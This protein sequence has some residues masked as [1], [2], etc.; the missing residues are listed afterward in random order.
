MGVAGLLSPSLPIVK[1]EVVALIAE[2]LDNHEIAA[3]AF[4]SEGTVRNRIS[5][6]LQ[7]TGYKNRTQLAVAWWQAREG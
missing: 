4:I 5:S 6:S 3:A 7:K 1:Y 2:G